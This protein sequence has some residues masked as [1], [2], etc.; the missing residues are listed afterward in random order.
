[1]NC[2]QA[3][4]LIDPYADGELD[5]SAVLELEQHLQSCSACAQ[6]LRNVQQVKKALKQEALYFTAPAELRRRI[7]GEMPS[8]T[9]TAP[10]RSA[11]NWNWNWLTV[12]TSGAFA[13][14]LALLVAVTLSRPSAEQALAREVVSSHIRSL[15]P[16]HTMD[17]VSTDQHTVKPWFNGRIDYAP[18][19]KDLSQQEFPLIGGRLDYVDGRNAAALVYQ[20]HKHVINLFVWPATGKSAE[21]AAIAPIQGFNVIH[22]SDGQMSYWA[23]SDLNESELMEFVKD[24]GA[25]KMVGP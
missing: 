21:P 16:G 12:G 15:M 11:W 5:A 24:F 13:I 6:A 22:W 23:V 20:R 1:M 10:R 19:V 3:K 2:Q 25:G 7:Q 18:P 4:P 9:K 8:P 14:C 17:V